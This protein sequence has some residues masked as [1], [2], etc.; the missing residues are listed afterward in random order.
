MNPSEVHFVPPAFAGAGGRYAASSRPRFAPIG[1][2]IGLARDAQIHSRLASPS[3][4]DPAKHSG[5]RKL[6]A[7]CGNQRAVVVALQATYF[8]VQGHLLASGDHALTCA[9]FIL[10]VAGLHASAIKRISHLTEIGLIDLPTITQC[11]K[12]S[13]LEQGYFRVD[14]HCDS[15]PAHRLTGAS[16]LRQ[17]I[18]ALSAASFGFDRQN[19]RV[20]VRHA[21]SPT[22]ADPGF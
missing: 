1:S 22:H 8:S 13:V 6:F 9:P 7:S 20:L 15:S 11:C 2:A 4:R 12:K 16:C 21:R 5:W 3:S 18:N 19:H 17:A 10:N 14:R